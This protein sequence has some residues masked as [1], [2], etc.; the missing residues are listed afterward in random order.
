V[1][2]RGF[3]HWVRYPQDKTR[4]ALVLSPLARNQHANDVLVV[5]CSTQL[6]LGPWHVVLRRG[7]GGVTAATVLKCEHVGPVPKEWVLPKPMGAALT[8]ER[9]RQVREAILSAAGFDD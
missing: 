1:I 2:R 5:P 9:L 6:R 4:P 7:E 3:L 8:D